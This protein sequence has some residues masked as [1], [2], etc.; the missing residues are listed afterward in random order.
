VG[1]GVDD[2]E[3]EVGDGLDGGLEVLEGLG[4]VVGWEFGV[5]EEGVEVLEGVDVLEVGV[6]EVEF[7]AEGVFGV[8][9][10]VEE[11]GGLR[12]AHFRLPNAD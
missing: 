1:D 6:E 7:W 4:G 12:I 10:G 2:E 3:C 9:V 11:E 5:G 8:V